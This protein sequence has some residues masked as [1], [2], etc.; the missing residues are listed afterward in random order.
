MLE[1]LRRAFAQISAAFK[2]LN[3]ARATK[4]MPLHVAGDLTNQRTAAVARHLRTC[5]S[6]R[7]QAD[8][9]A[10][11]RTWLQAG[12][13]VQFEA[14]FYDEIRATVLSQI[15]QTQRPAPPVAAPFFAPPFT[16]QSLYVAA[17]IALLVLVGMVVWRATFNRTDIHRT[18]LASV[19][20]FVETATTP[21]VPAPLTPVNAPVPEPLPQRA[22]VAKR[23]V[24]QSQTVARNN[25]ASWPP[26]AVN[27]AEQPEHITAPAPQQNVAASATSGGTQ[28]ANATSSRAEVA[29]IELQTA[30][31][32]I[33][34]IWLAEQPPADDAQP[35]PEKR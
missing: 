26:R 34:I 28:Q 33:R 7:A 15:R 31:P 8:E 24:S 23:Y 5:A 20:A 25:Q 9:Y 18:T 6:C 17:S 14:E 30:D 13:Q 3:C 35:K 4:L 22:T 12:A 27:R 19:N 11:S 32:N 16:R 29:R 1:S 2:R 21:K 10:A